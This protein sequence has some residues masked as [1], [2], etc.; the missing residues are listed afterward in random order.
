[1]KIDDGIFLSDHTVPSDDPRILD[2]LESINKIRNRTGFD[3]SLIKNKVWANK[4]SKDLVHGLAKVDEIGIEKRRRELSFVRNIEAERIVLMK[5]QEHLSKNL[6]IVNRQRQ[7]SK[8]LDCLN[9]TL[10]SAYSH[11]HRSVSNLKMYTA[12]L[13]AQGGFFVQ[14]TKEEEDQSEEIS[15]DEEINKLS[16][17]KRSSSN[18]FESK[19]LP[20]I[21]ESQSWPNQL[22]KP[23]IFSLHRHLITQPAG[24]LL[25]VRSPSLPSIQ[26][27]MT[28][29][30]HEEFR[31]CGSSMP[32]NLNFL[33]EDDEESFYLIEETQ[34]KEK[35]KPIKTL[36]NKRVVDSPTN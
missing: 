31:K 10:A 28:P 20:Q 22:K 2:A 17:R 6:I 9:P 11:L 25:K 15:S 1:M 36:H 16:V 21:E 19:S 18:E 26:F 4:L 27:S 32:Q 7:R 24:M 23:K 8:S 5:R 3:P 12:Q 14:Q 30:P 35:G 29:D 13:E 33:L 34:Q